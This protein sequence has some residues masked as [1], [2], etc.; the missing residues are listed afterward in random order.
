[1]IIGSRAER[2][3]GIRPVLPSLGPAAGSLAGAPGTATPSERPC[4]I[5]AVI[6]QAVTVQAVSVDYFAG[7]QNL[8]FV[9]ALLSLLAAAVLVCLP[10][11]FAQVLRRS[12]HR[13]PVI[14]SAAVLA[15]IALAVAAWSAGVGVRALAAE[16]ASVQAAIRTGYGVQLTGDQVRELIDGGAPT[17]ALPAQARAAGLPNPD[18]PKPLTLVPAG[19]DTYVLRIGGRRWP[20]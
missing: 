11:A 12:R 15:G 6:I 8:V 16:R 20:G 13:A 10:I 17:K 5:E 19:A 4:T 7:D 9:P 18:E 2:R 14:A 1:M 3:L